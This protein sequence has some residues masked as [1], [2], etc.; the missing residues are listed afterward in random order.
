[1]ETLDIRTF[2]LGLDFYIHYPHENYVEEFGR[3][4][5][6]AMAVGLPVIMPPVFEPTFKEAALYAEPHEVWPAIE[7]VWKNEGEWQARSDASFQFVQ[8]QGDWAQL[9]SRLAG[10]NT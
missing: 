7:R 8:S 2:L 3:A 4:V 6:E 9:A 1:P 10:L 5:L